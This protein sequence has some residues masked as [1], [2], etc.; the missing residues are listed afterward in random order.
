MRFREHN[1]NFSTK[2]K[3]LGWLELRWAIHPRLHGVRFPTPQTI[4]EANNNF[5]TQKFNFK[6]RHYRRSA[7]LARDVIE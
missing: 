6:L 5:E 2:I 4:P 3:I 7:T 1:S